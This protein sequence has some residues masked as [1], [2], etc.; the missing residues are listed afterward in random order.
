MCINEKKN[1]IS[2]SPKISIITVVF[3]CEK[4]IEK[5]IAS[6]LNQNYNNL[7]FIIIDGKSTDK[8]LEIINKYREHIT[9]LISEK[10]NGIYDAMNKGISHSTGDYAIFMNSGDCFYSENVLNEISGFLQ[11]K[12]Y[13]YYGDYYDRS[14][15][16]IICQKN[17]NNIMLININ[18][19]SIF[20]SVK[21]LKKT[22]FN[23]KYKILA[24]WDL[25]LR[26]YAKNKYLYIDRII[27]DYEGNGI[28]ATRNDVIF[29][30][31]FIKI[32]FIN[33]KITGLIK[34]IFLR[35][36][37]KIKNLKD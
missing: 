30:K 23:L 11:N 31:D 36:K 20:Y 10:D 32:I 9:C 34:Y 8:T 25:N 13:T 19:Q 7:E 3:N 6:I 21:Q 16:T 24:D 4:T 1:N 33:Y 28:S 26:L 22:S 12:D 17:Y 18:H 5:T 35:I 29:N 37:R 14:K 2:L 15:G 27:A